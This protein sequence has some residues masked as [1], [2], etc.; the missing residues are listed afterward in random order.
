MNYKVGVYKLRADRSLNELKF[1]FISKGSENIVKV[2]QY[3]FIQPIDGCEVYNLGFGDYDL[4]N[5]EIVDNITTE[6][7]DVYKVFNTVLSTIPIFFEH[8]PHAI[9]MVRGSD[10]NQEF[11]ENCRAF[12]KRKCEGSCKNF[13]RRIKLYCAYINK[14]FNNLEKEYHLI[15]GFKDYDN[16]INTEKFIR[17]KMYD[18]V[19]LSRKNHNFIK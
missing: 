19:F 2:V 13:N 11:L 10:S 17:F 1:F 3:S 18:T 5:D 16:Q 9:L 6:N 4:E 12:C 14:N 8:F 7:G 15:G